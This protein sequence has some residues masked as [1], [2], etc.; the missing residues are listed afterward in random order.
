MIFF[1]DNGFKKYFSFGNFIFIGEI[2]YISVKA[3]N[4]LNLEI[5]TANGQQK[6][7]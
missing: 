5:L 6:I 1:Q 7:H 2:L 3:L 4:I